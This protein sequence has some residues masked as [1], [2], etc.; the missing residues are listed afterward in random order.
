V[1]RTLDQVWLSRACVHAQNAHYDVTDDVRGPL[2]TTS[3]LVPN[4][5]IGIDDVRLEYETASLSL[6]HFGHVS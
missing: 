6:V 2:Y 5:S 4:S 3:F 1:C